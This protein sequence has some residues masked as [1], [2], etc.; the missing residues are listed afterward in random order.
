MAKC[1][2]TKPS[3]LYPGAAYRLCATSASD[4]L[5]DGA[6]DANANGYY[7]LNMEFAFDDGQN[8]GFNPIYIGPTVNGMT[9]TFVYMRASAFVRSQ[10]TPLGAI[11]LYPE[12]QTALSTISRIFSVIAPYAITYRPDLALMLFQSGVTT[13]TAVFIV[14]SSSSTFSPWLL[15]EIPS[16]STVQILGATNSFSIISG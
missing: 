4:L 12:G 8:C 10:S 15:P 7:M 6:Q 5:I 16:S 13:Y 3:K 9:Y 2:C 14:R 11:L 1:P